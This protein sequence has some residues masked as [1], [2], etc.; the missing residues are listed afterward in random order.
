MKEMLE[1]LKCAGLRLFIASTG[2]REH[3]YDFLT[4]GGVLPLFERIGFDE[5]VKD[6]MT[7]RLLEG[8]DPA[9]AVFV[10]DS[11]KDVQAAHANGLPA[12]GAGFGYVYSGDGQFDA[13]YDT[14]A[15]LACA[16]LAE[17]PLI[18]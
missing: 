4:F 8:V 14:P 12:L 15:E 7:A 18:P 6:A 10:G 5:P 9:R 3:V 16:L 13:V 17:E 1:Q 2:T 11:G